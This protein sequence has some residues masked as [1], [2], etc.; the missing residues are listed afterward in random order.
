MGDGF[1]ARH[2]G[3]DFTAELVNLGGLVNTADNFL[4]RLADIRDISFGSE[5]NSQVLP[6]G[7]LIYLIVQILNL[8]LL[9]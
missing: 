4:D 1:A 7:S 2:A 9:L 6:S 5:E 8:G 3:F